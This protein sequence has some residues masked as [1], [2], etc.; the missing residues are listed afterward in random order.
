[1][2]GLQKKHDGGGSGGGDYGR[3]PDNM[4]KS[5]ENTC[6][7]KKNYLVVRELN[8]VNKGRVRHRDSSAAQDR[9]YHPLFSWSYHL[10][11]SWSP[12]P[13]SFKTL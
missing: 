4:V 11:T 7:S 6:I 10:L 3:I 1:M 9:L 5:G 8:S 12:P 2:L 13:C